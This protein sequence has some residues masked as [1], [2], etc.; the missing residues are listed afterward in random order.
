MVFHYIFFKN[1]RFYSV[2][3]HLN[4]SFSRKLVIGM[5]Y[6]FDNVFIINI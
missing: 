2:L 1:G 6:A 4:I 5:M 3:C